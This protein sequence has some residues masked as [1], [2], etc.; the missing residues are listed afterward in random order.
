MASVDTVLPDFAVVVFGDGSL[1]E[2][3]LT[4]LQ[5]RLVSDLTV[6][7]RVRPQHLA[8]LQRHIGRER[9]VRCRMYLVGRLAARRDNPPEHPAQ[10]HP[11]A[12]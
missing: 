2:M 5:F 1:P 12:A 4:C 11:P 8:Q 10:E 7:A 9:C 6:D 3:L